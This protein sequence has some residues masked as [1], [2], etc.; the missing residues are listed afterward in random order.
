ME[1]TVFDSPELLLYVSSPYNKLFFDLKDF[2]ML[3]GTQIKF[4]KCI[5]ISASFTSNLPQSHPTPS[6]SEVT[7]ISSEFWVAAST[8]SLCY[9]WRSINQKF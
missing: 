7:E 5:E 1:G 2:A 9:K 6:S 4:H 3:A 8:L